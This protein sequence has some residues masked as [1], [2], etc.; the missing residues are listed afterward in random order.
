MANY[1]LINIFQIQ[2]QNTVLFRT[3]DFLLIILLLFIPW[4]LPQAT[5]TLQI[6]ITI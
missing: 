4:Y 3:K 5:I 1:F 6:L 2:I